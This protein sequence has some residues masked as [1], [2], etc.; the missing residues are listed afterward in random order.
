MRSAQ[1][2]AS[3]LVGYAIKNLTKIYSCLAIHDAPFFGCT[4]SEYDRLVQDIV[5]RLPAPAAGSG[6]RP[7]Q[8]V[9][10]QLFLHPNQDTF[11]LNQIFASES[12]W[13]SMVPPGTR[14]RIAKPLLS[15]KYD[16]PCSMTLCNYSQ[17]SKLSR[18]CVQGILGSPRC[19]CSKPQFARFRY[20][21][22]G[23]IVTTSPD[24]LPTPALRE[25]A[26]RGS[27]FRN[28]CVEAEEDQTVRTDLARAWR[29]W[30]RQ[31]E[32]R[33]GKAFA[34]SLGPWMKEVHARMAVQLDNYS[35]EDERQGESDSADGFRVVKVTDADLNALKEFHR[36]IVVTTIDKC[37]NNFAFLC[38]KHYLATCVSELE[39]ND[40]YEE[41]SLSP[42][43]IIDKGR[44]LNVQNGF[45]PSC[46]DCQGV[47][48]FHI[49]VKM[50]K[51]PVGYRFVCGAQNAPTHRISGWLVPALQTL[52]GEADSLWNEQIERLPDALKNGAPRGSWIALNSE[53]VVRKLRHCNRP[54]R[55]R[56]VPLQFCTYDFTT[57]YTKIRLSDLKSRLTDL[58]CRLFVRRQ[59]HGFAHLLLVR[60]DKTHQWLNTRPSGPNAIDPKTE[61]LFTFSRLVSMVES[62]VDNTYL[63]FGGR[64]YRQ[65]IGL[66]MGTQCAGQLA[67]LYCLTYELEYL[68]R[69]IDNGLFHRAR[70]ALNVTRYIDDLLTIGIPDFD[71][72]R[73]TPHGIYPQE[74]LTLEKA[75]EGTRVP[76]L[77]ISISQTLK[78]GI[79]TAI[80]DKRLDDKY[81]AISVIRY[82]SMDS[83]LAQ[84]CKSGILRSQSHRFA[85]LCKRLSD[86]SY[87]CALVIHRMTHKGYPEHWLWPSLR[88]FLSEHPPTTGG[89]RSWP[90]AHVERLVHAQLDRLRTHKIHPGPHGPELIHELA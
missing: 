18:H 20:E 60:K 79:T 13:N 15:Y 77:D 45:G 33:V 11:G 53:S 46:G 52:I 63:G 10:V 64:H 37:S 78:L 32:E 21:Q 35:G 2:S 68:R 12:L 83:R 22:V 47:P 9:V 8:S 6:A 55:E 41:T 72:M 86:F 58:F 80:F 5:A 90:V 57:M 66:P 81:T 73:Y 88:R 29:A 43:Q 74:I 71:S 38:K 56:R 17:T 3:S 14:A 51:T 67:N 42:Q 16:K 54:R 44:S 1:Y 75:D 69:L 31:M 76:Y 59:I 87:N 48:N 70:R 82:P 7:V 30:Y 26:R 40:T 34:S 62:L 84:K 49:R 61:C 50:H 24:I 89:A 28:G 25:L 27:M 85:R 65:S 19:A 23:H 39:G 4:T 36:D